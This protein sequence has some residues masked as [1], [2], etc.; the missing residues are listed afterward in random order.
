MDA[1]WLSDPFND[2]VIEVDM[3]L[4]ETRSGVI[5]R[6]YGT[7]NTPGFKVHSASVMNGSYSANMI[8]DY[9]GTTPPFLPN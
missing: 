3:S 6:S 9:T 4:P 8:F 7:I 1:G 5:V 2:Q